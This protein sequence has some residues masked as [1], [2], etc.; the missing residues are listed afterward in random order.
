MAIAHPHLGT[1]ALAHLDTAVH[2]QA[3]AAANQVAAASVA[4]V[5]QVETCQPCA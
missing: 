1:A 4:A 5:L 2:D 3:V